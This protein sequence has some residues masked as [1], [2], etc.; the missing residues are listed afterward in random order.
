MSGPPCPVQQLPRMSSS[1]KTNSVVGFPSPPPPV[2]PPPGAFTHSADPCRALGLC[3]AQGSVETDKAEGSS[4]EKPCS[5]R[6]VQRNQNDVTF[7]P[8]K[9]YFLSLFS[10]KLASEYG[11]HFI[12]SYFCLGF[13]QR[14][15]TFAAAIAGAHFGDFLNPNYQPGS[16]GSNNSPARAELG[17]EILRGPS[18]LPPLGAR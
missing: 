6:A 2:P 7:I 15:F 17:V 4:Q 12:I 13:P 18:S 14:G 1:W 9:V 11:V 16:V 8:S 10:Y 5:E 3:Q